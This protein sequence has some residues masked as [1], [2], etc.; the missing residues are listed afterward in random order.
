MA[1][2]T[3]T[4]AVVTGLFALSATLS[5]TV[6]SASIDADPRLPSPTGARPV[7]TT[8]LYLKDTSRPDPW[9]PSVK[10]RELMVSVWY[11]AKAQDGRRAQYMTPKESELLLKGAGVTGV[12]GDVLSKTRTHAYRDAPPAGR[13]HRLPLVVLSPGFSW[14]RSS[15]TSLAED[16]ASQGYVVA[17]IDHT[18]E[19][20][21]TTFPDGRVTTCVACQAPGDDVA[22]RATKGRA[23]DV[24]F[25]LDQILSGRTKWKGDALIDR[26]RVAMAGMSLG[27]ASASETMLRDSRVRAGINMDGSQQVAIP[28]RGLKRPFM[29]LGQAALDDTWSR[30]WPQL[31]GWKRW[32]Q[33]QGAIHPSF[34][35]YDMLTQQIG[36]DFGSKLPGDRSVVITRAYV[37]AFMDLHLR[38]RP[39]PL[40][41]GPSAR[42]PE[43][44]FKARDSRS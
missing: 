14:P 17:G 36:L 26:S 41:D 27:G 9:V 19:N 39:Q 16:L 24:S 34:A 1:S 35:D 31:K 43:V 28:R 23:I 13:A 33:V 5:P 30:D 21:A 7:G 20:H 42:Y 25:V 10:A 38:H 3:R 37:R 12:P 8:S 44:T 2:R 6:A 18:Y 11:P 4:V 29:F 32:L 40:L 15:L 22:A